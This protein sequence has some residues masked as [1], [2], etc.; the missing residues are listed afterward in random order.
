M[1]DQNHDAAALDTKFNFGLLA[2]VL[3]TFATGL[4]SL[5]HPQPIDGNIRLT[6]NLPTSTKNDTRDQRRH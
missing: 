5:L 2:P 3:L 1:A 6:P 4:P